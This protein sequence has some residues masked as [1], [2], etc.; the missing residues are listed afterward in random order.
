M[1]PYSE[2]S[3]S[4]HNSETHP[5]VSAHLPD[6]LQ[7]SDSNITY[8]L[9]QIFWPDCQTQ[10]SHAAMPDSC[11]SLY[12]RATDLQI[13]VIASC[14]LMIFFYSSLLHASAISSSRYSSLFSGSSSLRSSASVCFS[15]GINALYKA[16][17]TISSL[18][19]LVSLP[20]ASFMH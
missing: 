7:M 8:S 11:I 19:C 6:T 5:A 3:R 1:L 17:V 18:I 10:P 20:I 9:S 15:S 14:H 4:E 2:L 16:R 13:I 12:V